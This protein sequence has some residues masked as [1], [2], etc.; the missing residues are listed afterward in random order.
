MNNINF[1]NVSLTI[2]AGNISQV[3]RDMP[4]IAFSGRSNVGKSSLL[5]CLTRRKLLARV[6]AAPGKTAQVNYFLVNKTFYLVDLPG[7]GYAKVSHKERERWGRL[8]SDFFRDTSAIV[9]GLMVVDLRH[10]PTVDDIAMAKLFREAGV[11]FAVAA[12]KR[13]KLKTTQAAANEAVIRETLALEPGQAL[14]P[15]SAEQGTGRDALIKAIIYAVGRDAPGAPR[16][17]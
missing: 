8:M 5:N 17:T 6:S 15:C 12:N 7:Y 4:H 2:S 9:L 1:Q 14:V 16:T 11:P 3:P 13:D 10:K